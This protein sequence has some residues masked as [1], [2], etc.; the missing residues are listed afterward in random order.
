MKLGRTTPI[1]RIF[2]LAK[3]KEFYVDFLGFKVDWQHRFEP[4]LPLYAT[5]P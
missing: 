5:E 3:A 2:D 1:L 4:D